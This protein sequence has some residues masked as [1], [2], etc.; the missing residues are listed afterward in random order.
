MSHTE[1]AESAFTLLKINCRDIELDKTRD[2][3]RWRLLLWLDNDV[4]LQL[5]I[6]HTSCDDPG[7]FIAEMKLVGSDDPAGRSEEGFTKLSEFMYCAVEL[8]DAE[9]DLDGFPDV[10][11]DEFITMVSY[12][13]QVLE[14]MECGSALGNM[15][16]LSP[17]KA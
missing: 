16:P 4:V 13:G 5:R 12:W 9:P 7:H 1:Q 10:F 11:R 8:E 2:G 15:R 17:V 14:I 6:V 3:R